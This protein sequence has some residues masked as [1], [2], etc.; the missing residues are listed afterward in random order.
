MPPRRLSAVPEPERSAAVAYIRVSA[1]MGREAEQFHSPD[2]QHHAIAELLGRRGR[3]EVARIEDIDRTGRDFNRE[4]IHRLLAMAKAR[5]VD[6]VALYDFSRLGRNTAEAL[7]VIAELRSYGVAVV[8]TVEQVDDSPEGQF[9]LTQFLSM[10]QLYSDQLGR[11]WRATH[12]HMA[13]QGRQVGAPPLGYYQAPQATKA[14]RPGGP[15]LVHPVMG[16]AVRQAFVDHA[17]G[18][19]V[20]EIA[21]RLTVARGGRPVWPAQVRALLRRRY[22]LGYVTLRGQEF[23]GAHEPLV[24][25]VTFAA[26]QRRLAQDAKENGRRLERAASL[27]GLAVCDACDAH[28]TLRSSF[29]HGRRVVRMGCPRQSDLKACAGCGAMRL[30][31]IE[32]AVLDDLRVYLAALTVGGAEAASLRARRARSQADAARLKAELQRTR[33]ARARML[34]DRALR[35]APAHVWAAADADLAAAEERLVLALAE[36]EAVEAPAPDVAVPAI[37]AVLDL[38]GDATPHERNRLLVPVV[39]QVRLRAGTRWREPVRERVET[40]PL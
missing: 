29:E 6:V 4:G 15:A 31:L 34:A 8:S 39:R 26:C 3:R 28:A 10:A 7:R 36:V 18:A 32:A 11:R 2:L 16:P 19:R 35:D 33:S 21:D 30:E 24:D 27:S 1:V 22:Y 17:A 12:E 14:G 25:E 40:V 23:A 37:E 5:Q 9:M 13:R 20:R 38:W